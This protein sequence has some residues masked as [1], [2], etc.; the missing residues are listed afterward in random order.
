MDPVRYYTRAD[1]ESLGTDSLL[2]V[3]EQLG[4]DFQIKQLI[5]NALVAKGM[6]EG[7]P[8]PS[9]PFENKYP[10]AKIMGM[11]P[12]HV[13]LFLNLIPELWPEVRRLVVAELSRRGRLREP[14]RLAGPAS[15]STLMTK[16]RS[17]EQ[18]VP[19]EVKADLVGLIHLFD[20]GLPV[21]LIVNTT[22]VGYDYNQVNNICRAISNVTSDPGIQIP[23]DTRAR[24][25]ALNESICNENSHFWQLKVWEDFGI[26]EKTGDRTWKQEYLIQWNAVKIEY[27]VFG[28][29]TAIY[30]HVRSS[31]SKSGMSGGRVNKANIPNFFETY[32]KSSVE[33][34]NRG[35]GTAENLTETT[36]ID[37][38]KFG[39]IIPEMPNI[40]TLLT[41][42]RTGKIFYNHTQGDLYTLDSA[43][44]LND[45]IRQ[46]IQSKYVGG[47]QDFTRFRGEHELIGPDVEKLISLEY[48][49]YYSAVERS[50]YLRIVPDKFLR[51][52]LG[53]DPY[54]PGDE[55][56]RLTLRT[57][58]ND[59]TPII[60]KLTSDRFSGILTETAEQRSRD[61]LQEL[62][63][64]GIS[65]SEFNEK[66]V[67]YASD[68]RRATEIEWLIEAGA[69]VN[70]MSR[71][72]KTAL[73]EAVIHGNGNIASTL[74]DAGAD[75]GLRNRA[76]QN[77]SD[78]AEP[79]SAIYFRL[80]MIGT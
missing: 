77:A 19:V 56:P 55:Y 52:V 11:T 36:T 44:V 68:A 35:F 49:S 21:E 17:W 73:T 37:L 54:N 46:S 16:Y 15:P 14:P 13:L 34:Y 25:S 3:A 47:W 43:N 48:S 40:D 2:S 33:L 12:E 1:V 45:I 38:Y 32:A 9:I 50:L 71:D 8:N 72:G 22:V 74:L 53:I 27:L 63:D 24:L 28:E 10:Y 39:E 6:Y 57:F 42:S 41:G 23:A 75:P 80:K 76:G 4:L 70:Y 67:E 59:I 78:L 51:Q 79:F 69:D 7:S 20:K 60:V 58:G 66:L 62:A 65:P 26:T 31:M 61:V 64:M 29:E 18:Q 5:W 30:N